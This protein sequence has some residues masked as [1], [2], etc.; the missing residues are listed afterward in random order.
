MAEREMT[1]FDY[2]DFYQ[3]LTAYYRKHPQAIGWLRRTNTSIEYLMYG[4]YLAQLLGLVLAYNWVDLG[5]TLLIPS[6]SFIWLSW[7]R[8]S[9]N[10]P[11]PYETWP[12]EALIKKDTKGAS[13][14]SRHVFSASLISMASWQLWPWVAVPA[15]GLSLLLA[16]CRVAGGVH[17]VK[18][19]L[20]GYGL[21]L[22]SS[23][24]LLYLVA[25]F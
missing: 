14:P 11:R 2:V 5:M 18:D 3:N 12:I 13:M 16:Y 25:V 8:R 6:I 10:R 22:L 15:L 21:G 9:L 24:L 23:W 17:Y 20:V 4:L 7:M 1:P 19:V